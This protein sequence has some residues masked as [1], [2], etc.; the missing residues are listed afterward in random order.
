MFGKEKGTS[1]TGCF[2]SELTANGMDDDDGSINI[3]HF[4][5]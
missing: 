3:Q 1:I 5:V 4:K 2:A